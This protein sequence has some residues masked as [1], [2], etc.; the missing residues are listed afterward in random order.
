MKVTR[1][2]WD[3]DTLYIETEDGNVQSF[4]GAYMTGY[5]VEYPP[6]DALTIETIDFTPISVDSPVAAGVTETEK[7]NAPGDDCSN[8]G[9][10]SS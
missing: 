4:Q 2:Y 3:D 7:T 8:S 10:N 9:R 6:S 1:L 5:S